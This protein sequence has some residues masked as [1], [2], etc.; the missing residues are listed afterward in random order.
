MRVQGI[1]VQTVGVQAAAVQAIE[2]QVASKP[3]PEVATPSW[4]HE[5]VVL[6]ATAIDPPA[7]HGDESKPRRNTPFIPELP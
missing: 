1:G 4:S 6:T 5:E 3:E 2:V 7:Q